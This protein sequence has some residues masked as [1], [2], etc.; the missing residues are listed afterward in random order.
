MKAVHYHLIIIGIVV[1]LIIV[2]SILAYFNIV[3]MK[4]INAYDLIITAALFFNT[5]IICAMN[6]PDL[7]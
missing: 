4:T 6:L 1:M 3:W 7:K 2:R 5:G